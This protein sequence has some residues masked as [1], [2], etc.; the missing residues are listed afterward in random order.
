MVPA[1]LPAAR[2]FSSST[3]SVKGDSTGKELSVSPEG[4]FT[5]ENLNT[6]GQY[7]LIARG[8][9]GDRAVAGIHYATAPTSTS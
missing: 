3:P 8:K 7:K 9:T 4:Y 2:R 1:G 6:G 5:I